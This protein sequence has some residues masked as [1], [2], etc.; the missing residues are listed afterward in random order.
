LRSQVQTTLDQLDAVDRLDYQPAMA[1]VF[2]ENASIERIVAVG[3][4][5]YLLNVTDGVV[6]RAIFTNQGYQV[7]P[8]F[9]CGPGPAGGLII[10]ALKDVAA[11]PEGNEAN[12]TIAA[13][14]GNGN[15]L[16]CMPGSPPLAA[17]MQ[18]PD[19][20]WGTPQGMAVDGDNLY[21]LDPQT[22]AVWIYRNMDVSSQP[23]LFFGDQI[24]PMQRCDRS[25]SQPERSLPVARRWAFNDL[26]LQRICRIPD[27]L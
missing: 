17:S 3:N 9:E 13:I 21:I 26:C 15:L 12:A 8:T 10:G 22:N 25:S 23:R 5:L 6:S 4:D 20:N 7:D 18:P 19:T 11:L 27:S 2:D 16:Q 14:D 1:N 24:P